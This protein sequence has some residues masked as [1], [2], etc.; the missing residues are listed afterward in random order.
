MRP[1]S[2][3][4]ATR[5]RADDLPL[6]AA[7][8]DDRR[9]SRRSA[10]GRVLQYHNVTPASYLRALRSGA[11]PAGRARR[12]R[13]WRRWPA[14]SIWRS[15]TRSTTGRSSRRSASRRPASFRSPSTRRASRSRSDRPALDDDSRRRPRELP[16]RRPDRAEQE[17][18][19]SH[20]AGRST[21]SATSTRTTASSSSAATT[22]CRGI[23]R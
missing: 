14:A 23:I 12:D 20:P 19:G 5:G 2:D 10:R 9:R 4:A 22:W 3:P 15:A 13:S 21:T 18:R 16:V 11:V 8:A 17:D 1:F 6:R 7:V